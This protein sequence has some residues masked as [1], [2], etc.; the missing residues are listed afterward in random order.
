[1]QPAEVQSADPVPRR[2]PVATLSLWDAVSLIVGVVIGAGIYETAPIVLSN[3]AGPGSALLVWLLGGV[4]SLIGACCYAE[5][6]T[7]YPRS[8]GDYVYLRRAFGSCAAFLFGWA[9]L[10]VILTGSIGMMAYVFADYAARFGFDGARSAMAALAVCTL[11]AL[12]LLSVWAGKNTQNVL[13]AVKIAGL[14]AI[15]LLGFGWYLTHGSSTPLRATAAHDTSLGLA[16]II[17]LYTYGG[18]NDAAFVAAEVRDRRNIA[19][20]LLLGTALITLV[21][22]LVNGAFLAVLGFEGAR[23]S[24]AIAADLLRRPLGDSG[25]AAISV[26]VMISALGAV[27]ALVLTGARVHARLGRDFSLLSALGRW[28]PRR[29]SPSAALLAQAAIT[30]AWIA[31]VGT[32]GGRAAVDTALGA[33]GLG[34]ASWSGHG[35]FDT[36]LRCTAPVF[37]LFFLLTGL[38]LFVLRYREPERPRPFRVPLYPLTPLVFCAT[39]VYM[40]VSA[41]DYAGPLTLVG[42]FLVLLGLPLYFASKQRAEPAFPGSGATSAAE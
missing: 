14:A 2:G 28:H 25:A 15:T 37:W 27:N 40:L 10:A 4:L 29:R 13:T 20:A 11:T 38:S 26:L 7:A 31:L 17:V 36:L 39:C 23:A 16:L 3:V 21:Y 9:Q 24:Q 12:N 30:L 32:S 18:W 6:A 35:G 22:L 42:V 41:I 33:L 34:A 1:M 5:L 8:G 19:R